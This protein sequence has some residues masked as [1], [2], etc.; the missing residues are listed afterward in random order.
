MKQ[1]WSTR[2]SARSAPNISWRRLACA[3]CFR[4]PQRGSRCRVCGLYGSDDQ[5]P[6]DL[7]VLNFE[8]FKW[9][10][11]RTDHVEYVAFDLEQ[12]ARAPRLRPTP[13]DLDLGR[14]II[15]QLRDL[16]P[17]TTAARAVTHLKMVKGNKAERDTLMGILGVCGILQTADHPGYTASFVNAC[18]RTLPGR[19]YVDQEYPACWWTAGDGINNEALTIFLPE[20]A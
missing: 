10:G 5:E 6:E 1:S 2:S 12:F 14:Q 3:S 8:R 18:D 11:V 16:P 20:L 19:R 15:A 7:N 17:D 13:A 4:E 9:G